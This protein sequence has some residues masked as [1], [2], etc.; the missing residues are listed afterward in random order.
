MIA[1]EIASIERSR[2][3]LFCRASGGGKQCPITT[4]P[5]GTAKVHRIVGEVKHLKRQALARC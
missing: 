2:S 4:Q 5:P 1:N 3:I